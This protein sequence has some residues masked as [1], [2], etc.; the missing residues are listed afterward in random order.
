MSGLRLTCAGAFAAAGIAACATPPPTAQV[1]DEADQTLAAAPLCER[2]AGDFNM[3]WVDGTAETGRV[4][5]RRFLSDLVRS[6][7]VAFQFEVVDERASDPCAPAGNGMICQVAGPAEL[8]LSTPDGVA[9]YQIASPQ[10]ARVA[11][12]G[13]KLTCTELR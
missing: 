5:Q 10:R 7:G 9:R 3:D 8:T 11:S 4:Y 1:R 12:E 13:A 2:M 6:R